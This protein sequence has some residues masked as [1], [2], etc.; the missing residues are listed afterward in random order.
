MFHRLEAKSHLEQFK[1]NQCFWQV[2]EIPFWQMIAFWL[3]TDVGCVQKP[4]RPQIS[5]VQ[6]TFFFKGHVVCSD[7]ALQTL[8]MISGTKALTAVTTV[9]YAVCG[10]SF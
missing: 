7:A 4:Q 6:R 5:A 10:L 8:P 1:Y 3:N 9:L 2:P